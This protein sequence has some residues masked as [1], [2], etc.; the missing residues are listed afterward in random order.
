M[1][2]LPV[3]AG[4]Q[5]NILKQEEF[6]TLI[7]RAVS[8]REVR[9]AEMVYP[10]Y[11]FDLSWALLRDDQTTMTPASPYDELKT[12]V[13]FWRRQYGDLKAF[14][15]TDP[16]DSVVADMQF[17]TGDGVTAAFQLIRGYGAGGFTFAEPVNNVNTMTNVKDNGSIIPAGAG[18]GK[19][20]INSTGLITFGTVPTAGHPLTWSGTYYYRVRFVLGRAQYNE[21]MSQ[22]WENKKLSFVGSLQNKV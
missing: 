5:W 4:L 9:V 21:F 7:Q 12:L 8:G 19:Y 17:G 3:L 15:Y 10:L 1:D 2:V 16:S 6:A 13:G 11:T 22:L 14:L 18:A 20:T